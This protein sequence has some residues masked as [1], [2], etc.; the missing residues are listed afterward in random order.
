MSMKKPRKKM[1]LPVAPFIVIPRDKLNKVLVQWNS[2]LGIKYAWPINRSVIGLIYDNSISNSFKILPKD[3]CI[4][5][6]ATT[7]LHIYPIH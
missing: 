4:M 3:T 1:K 6:T 2:G 5:D 7:K